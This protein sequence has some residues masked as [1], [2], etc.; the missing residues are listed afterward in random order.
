[1]NLGNLVWNPDRNFFILP[2]LNHPI[3]WYGLFFACGFLFGYFLIRKIFEKFLAGAHPVSHENKLGAVK[4]T[5]RL[6]LFVVTGTIL[7]ARLGHIFFYGWSYY[8]KYPFDM[9]KVWEGG[10]ASHGGAIG[11]FLSLIFFL[12]WNRNQFKKITLLSVL[13]SMVIPAAF[14]GGCI[15]IGNF[16]NQEITGI[17]TT[18]P[19]GVVFGTPLDGFPG[20]PVHP[21]QLYESFLYFGV[22]IFLYSR[23]RLKPSLVATGILSGWFF[24]LVFGC[25]FLLEFLKVSHSDWIEANSIFTMGQ[26][27]SI[28]F[29]LL[30]ILLLF[31]YQFRTKK[32]VASS[33]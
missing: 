1:M 8:K 22:F 33:H 6:A 14:A 3:T 21:V 32:N 2:Y 13:D 17:P 12:L 5:D 31:Y 10:L 15:R 24:T 27:L 30:G 7:G 19:W 4:L 23:W 28:P 16:I 18:L 20:I 9:I 29:V 26:I 25:R 11:I